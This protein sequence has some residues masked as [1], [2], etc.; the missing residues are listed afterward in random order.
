METGTGFDTRVR[1]SAT[2]SA[3][4]G[5]RMTRRVSRTV[6]AVMPS[7]PGWAS[8][9][10]ITSFLMPI[11]GEWRSS[12]ATRNSSSLKASILSLSTFLPP[13]LLALMT[14]GSTNHSCNAAAAPTSSPESTAQPASLALRGQGQLHTFSAHIWDSR[15][16][17][18]RQIANQTS[19]PVCGESLPRRGRRGCWFAHENG[20]FRA[21]VANGALRVTNQQEP[22]LRRGHAGSGRDAMGR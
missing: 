4:P 8:F 21:R 1:A 18:I 20:R 9:I 11:S 13:S 17:S 2:R 10:L 7:R 6:F 19:E 3:P 15:T 16:L 14:R 22:S 5:P 12:K